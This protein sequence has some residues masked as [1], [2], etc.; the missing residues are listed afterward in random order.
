MNKYPSYIKN[1][2]FSIPYNNDPELIGKLDQLL[3]RPRDIEVYIYFAPNPLITNAGRK[4]PNLKRYLNKDEFDSKSFD[5][6]LFEALKNA[7]KCGFK[8]NLLLNNVL[9]GMPHFNSELK[10]EIPKIQDYLEEIYKEGILD[11][12]TIS[13]PYLLELI[14]W[15]RLK[16]VE[17]KTSVNFQIKSAK[18]IEIINNLT[19]YWLRKKIDAVEIQKDLLRN[20]NFLERIKEKTK[21]SIKLSIII[22]EGCI[23]NCPYQMAHQLFACSF[24]KKNINDNEELV[25]NTAKCK[26]ITNKEP[27]RILDSNWI[28]PENLGSYNKIIDEFKLT[29]RSDTTEN[30]L[31]IVKAYVFN[32]YD[33]DDFS[34]LISLLRFEN[35]LL[36]SKLLPEDFFLKVSSGKSIPDEYFIKIWKSIEKYNTKTLGQKPNIKIKGIIKSDLN[37]FIGNN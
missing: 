17:I 19:Q 22:N 24:P 14:N 16:N 10:N 25:F 28:L 35:I 27:W 11:R 26:Y 13:N 21:S 1:K 29:D 8:T 9:L 20:M 4:F 18:T 2:T 37:E 12:V 3:V 36:P 31:K 5:R 30:I 23:N 32:D 33:K 7:K 6:E 34:N 15:D